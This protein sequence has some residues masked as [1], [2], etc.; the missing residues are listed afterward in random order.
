[1]TR[2]KQVTV[3]VFVLSV[4]I[5]MFIVTRHIPISGAILNQVD[6]FDLPFIFILVFF[7]FVPDLLPLFSR[8]YIKRF[9]LGYVEFELTDK[10]EIATQQVE[11][12]VEHEIIGRQT[13]LRDHNEDNDR[14]GEIN[15]VF[16]QSPIAAVQ[17]IS[18][19]IE[20]NIGIIAEKENV[21]AYP[22]RSSVRQL[23]EK[24]IFPQEFEMAFNDFYAV[25]NQI[26]HGRYRS[27]N[28]R[29]VLRAFDIGYR[30]LKVI[31][32]LADMRHEKSNEKT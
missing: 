26:V 14:I 28:S 31:Y 4:L 19:E 16:K 30:I 7:C 1:M 5:I 11:K 20:R 15:G 12:A 3:K 25:R 29:S 24:R 9:K 8:D 13:I 21:T 18:S 27:S 23:V 32:V 10:A 17:L 6:K 2:R 22:L